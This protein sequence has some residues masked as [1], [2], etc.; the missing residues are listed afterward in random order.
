MPKCSLIYNHDDDG[1]DNDDDGDDDGDDDRDDDAIK[2]EDPLV[3]LPFR[4]LA[5]CLCVQ[6]TQAANGCDD[7]DS[8]LVML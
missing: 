1:D 2:D 7:D 5:G 3:R 6:L 4:C 8:S